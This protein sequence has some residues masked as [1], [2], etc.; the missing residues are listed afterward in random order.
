MLATAFII[1]ENKHNVQLSLL[2][3]LPTSLVDKSV[4]LCFDPHS[5]YQVFTGDVQPAVCSKG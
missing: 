3:L 5:N 2:Q 1:N 4:G